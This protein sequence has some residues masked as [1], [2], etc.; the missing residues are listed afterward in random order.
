MLLRSIQQTS[1]PHSSINHLLSMDSAYITALALQQFPMGNLVLSWQ[2]P[3]VL[4]P[5]N[6]IQLQLK[7]ITCQSHVVNVLTLCTPTQGQN[8]SHVNGHRVVVFNQS[9]F[10]LV[11]LNYYY[12]LATAL[13]S[14][15]P[16][17]ALIIIC[18]LISYSLMLVKQLTF[19]GAL[20]K[21][22]RFLCASIR[23]VSFARYFSS[24]F[25]LKNAGPFL[26]LTV[27]SK[28]L[29]LHQP[30]I[31]SEIFASHGLSYCEACSALK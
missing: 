25:F 16:P 7:R 8:V 24:P 10:L 22:T 31:A 4:Y 26:S 15:P 13:K 12:I 2:L 1:D 27:P 21:F 18:F 23:S 11:F 3:Y 30:C 14:Q 6:H 20:L 5:A 17:K 9:V 29:Q 19:L 28:C